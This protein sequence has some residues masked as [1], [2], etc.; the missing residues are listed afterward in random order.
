MEN[1]YFIGIDVSK[2]K[3]DICVMLE[4][5]VLK[6]EVACNYPQAIASVIASIK[7]ELSMDNDSFIICAEHTGQYTYP[8]MCASKSVGC[9][10]WLEN[11]SQLKYCSGITRG[12]N[13]KVDACRIAEYA[14]RFIDKAHPYERPSGELTRLKQLETERSLYLTDLAKYKAQ[15]SDQKG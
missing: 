13:D 7:K 3:L 11:P 9:K 12:K 15:L 4:S 1:F 8:L 2:S 6:E 10:L 5:R 14:M